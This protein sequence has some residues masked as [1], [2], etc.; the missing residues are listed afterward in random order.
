MRGVLRLLL[1]V[2]LLP[3]STSAQSFQGLG[4]LPE[5]AP[6]IIPYTDPLG[7]SSDGSVVVGM[8]Y[9]GYDNGDPDPDKEAFRWTA[10]GGMVSLGDWPGGYVGSWAYDVSSDGS[11]V[12]GVGKPDSGYEAFRWTTEY[13]MMTLG[14]I[15]DGYNSSS[16]SAVSS[17]GS[18]VVGSNYI[19]GPNYLGTSDSS[20]AF[21]WTPDGG[22][23]GLGDLPGGS[24][25]SWANDVSPDGSVVVGS[26]TTDTRSEAFRWTAE[27]GMVGLGVLP[28]DYVSSS[29]T[30]VSS[31]GTT[32][33]GYCFGVGTRVEAFVWTAENGM[34]GLGSIPGDLQYSIAS[35]V[36]PDGSMVVG[37]TDYLIDGYYPARGA[38]LW[39]AEG[40]MRLLE[41]I[42][43]EEY[44]LDLGDWTLL[45]AKSI[46]DDGRVIVGT[47]WNPDGREEAWRAEL[48][49]APVSDEAAVNPIP[50]PNLRILGNP[51][52]HTARVAFDVP[53]PAR[54]RLSVVDALGREVAVALGDD[55][56]AGRHV[57]ELATD[58]LAPGV[59]VVRLTAGDEV[60]TQQFTV[61]R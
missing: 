6:N 58:G 60:A 26:G 34:V 54:V 28:G 36:S 3:C 10:D 48:W 16:A 39:T 52:H 19:V 53:A 40:G 56:P 57:I 55:R 51:V 14:A 8:A 9:S 46:S 33:I 11:V 45:T 42:L 2:L 21:V 59:Y 15:P 43:R 17:D 31:D 22:M 7:V 50:T 47:G 4:F 44:G 27:D 18:V 23:V 37:W 12:V 38:F 41:P 24:V 1:L 13:G 30:A 20:E 32:V 35:G 49:A 61:V 29:A 5:V 25:G